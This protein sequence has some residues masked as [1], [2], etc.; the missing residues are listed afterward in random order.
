MSAYLITLWLFLFYTKKSKSA[1]GV[2][3]L[4][5]VAQSR[6][7]GAGIHT[8]PCLT[9]DPIF[10]TTMLS[11]GCF[12]SCLLLGNICLWKWL[13]GNPKYHNGQL[14]FPSQTPS[15]AMCPG[16]V[17]AF[18]KLPASQPLPGCV[19]LCLALCAAARSES[20]GPAV[21]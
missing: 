14:Y 10:L 20:L 11:C 19:L 21:P 3:A 1:E 2:H 5:R 16:N 13:C 12:W 4:P 15:S 7:G 6:V 9:L 18:A 17:A 8:Q